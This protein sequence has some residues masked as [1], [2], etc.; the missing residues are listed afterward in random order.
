MTT[1]CKKFIFVNFNQFFVSVVL[2]EQERNAKR[3]LI[4]KNREKK[5]LDQLMNQLKD[6]FPCIPIN[7][8]KSIVDTVT[9]AYCRW[10]DPALKMD[11][12]FRFQDPMEQFNSLM[13]PLLARTFAFLKNLDGFKNLDLDQLQEVITSSNGWLEVQVL[14]AIHKIDVENWIFLIEEDLP[15]GSPSQKYGI[16]LGDLRFE[17]NVIEDLKRISESFSSLQMTTEEIA[18]LSTVMLFS[19]ALVEKNPEVKKQKSKIW[20]ILEHIVEQNAGLLDSGI[21]RWPKLLNKLMNFQMVVARH[22]RVFVE[23]TNAREVARLF[24]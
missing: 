8:V 10:I 1:D 22:S 24:T 16:P 14:K 6:S 12:H 21:D 18:L 19:E 23:A 15:Q 3:Q 11:S 2:D 20:S 7:E 9:E 5:E 17:K 13:T 4:E